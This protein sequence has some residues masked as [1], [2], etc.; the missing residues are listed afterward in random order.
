[1]LSEAQRHVMLHALGLTRAKESYRNYFAANPGT[2][3]CAIWEG[4]EASGLAQRIRPLSPDSLIVFCV[5]PAG[6][7]ALQG[8][9]KGETR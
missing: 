8:E 1:M 6:R 9:S 7:S 2:P 4:L 5:T 3:D